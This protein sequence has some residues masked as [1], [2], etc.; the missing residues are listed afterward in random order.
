M[1]D[2]EGDDSSQANGSATVDMSSMSE[3][4]L[5][6]TFIKQQQA[7]QEAHTDVLKQLATAILGVTPAAP[8]V[9]TA[10]EIREQKFASLYLTWIKQN[11]VKEFKQADNIDVCQWLQQF[12]S[13]IKNFA[14]AVCKLDLEAAPLTAQEFAK[15]LRYKLPHLVDTDIARALETVHK[16][17]ENATV[18]EIR[19]AMKSLYEKKEPQVCSLLKLFSTDRL[20]KGDQSCT[21]FIA[22]FKESLPPYLVCNTEDQYK[23][24]YDLV[25]RSAY[26]MGL[27]DE[28]LQKDL[29]KIP[30]VDQSLQKFYEESCAAESRTKLYKDTQSR[31][32][33]MDNNTNVSVSKSDTKIPKGRGGGKQWHS[34]EFVK[35]NSRVQNNNTHS[36]SIGNHQSYP[37]KNQKPVSNNDSN[38]K[39][40][41]G[42]GT[43][44]KVFVCYYCNKPGHTSKVCR[45]RVRD[46][47]QQQNNSN[48]RGADNRRVEIS[49]D[50]NNWSNDRNYFKKVEI[51]DID[52]I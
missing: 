3:L 6:K 13:N 18:D 21:N 9:Q 41:K 46:Q 17:W 22:K 39:S 47:G 33:A 32:H 31:G 19:T 37:G 45:T 1:S 15:L 49:S 20:K 35:D 11:K 42:T 14:S 30:E 12:D 40:Q 25:M 4:D 48:D 10:Q 28:G 7:T 34:N 50:G 2:T 16:T 51:Q 44:T 26:Y 8:V 36:S 27:D 23:N 38:G 24:F 52:E 29:S 43:K 5:L